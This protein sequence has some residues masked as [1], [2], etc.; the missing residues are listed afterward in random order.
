M[1]QRVTNSYIEQR[2]NL[3]WPSSVNELISLL[4]NVPL[5]ELYN[6]IFLTVNRLWKNSE[7]LNEYG[8]A[9]T[10]SKNI[11]KNNGSIASDWMALLT[12]LMSPKQI[13]LGLY[14]HRLVAN[15]EVSTILWKA[16]HIPLNAVRRINDIFL[17]SSFEMENMLSGLVKN[18]VTHAAFDNNDKCQD[19]NTGKRTTQHTNF[20]LF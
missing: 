1:T 9:E 17:N 19:T 14:I 16:G 4:G 18:T 20:F 7:R 5:S 15:K 13:S 11:A 3:D 2:K 10:K 6:T 12:S 8:F